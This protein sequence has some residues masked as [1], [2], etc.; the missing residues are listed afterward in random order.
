MAHFAEIRNDN[1]TVLRVIVVSNEDVNNN[2]GELSIQAETWVANNH[3]NDES[4]LEELG[5]TYPETY[6]KQT[7][8]N[9]NFRNK[10]AGKGWVYDSSIDKFIAPKQFESW[11]LNSS[12]DWEAPFPAPT[13]KTYGALFWNEE[14]QTY[15]TAVLPEGE[16]TPEMIPQVRKRWDRDT[17]SFIDG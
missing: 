8:Y 3:P 1:N 12:Y 13:D 7:S 4:I 6:W 9:N 5:G 17:N 11:T 10:Y 14:L 15:V 2:G 16:T